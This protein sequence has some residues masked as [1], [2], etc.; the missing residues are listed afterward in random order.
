VDDVIRTTVQ[1][2]KMSAAK[3]AKG[4]GDYDVTHGD[5]FVLVDRAGQIRG[6]YPT[7]DEPDV[8]RLTEDAER[9]DRETR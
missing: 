4:A 3:I 2:F 7:D 1:G 9:L 8:S 6:Y 5:W